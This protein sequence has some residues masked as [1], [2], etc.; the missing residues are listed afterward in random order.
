MSVVTKFILTAGLIA[1]SMLAGYVVRKRTDWPCDRMARWLMTFVGVFG[2]TSVS[3]LSIWKLHPVAA[4]AWLPSLGGL[5]V[6]LMTVLGLAAARLAGRPRGEVGLFSI[7]SGSGNNGFTMGGFIIFLLFGESGLGLVTMYSLMWTP[8]IVL[9][10]YP[11]ARHCASEKPTE[12]LGRLMLQNILDWRSIGLPITLV[13]LALA[14]AGVPRP[15]VIDRLNI[16][17][18]L[19]FTIT[20]MA[21]FG[22]GLRLH[23]ADVLAMRKTL[24]GL[25]VMRFVVALGVGL[26]LAAMTSLTPWPLTGMSRDV[27]IIEAFVPTAVTMVA[28]ANMFHLLPRQASVLFVVNTMMYLAV[29]LPVVFWVYRNN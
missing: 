12:S 8:M 23:V 2:Y 20:P 21:Y 27:F 18:V 9:L 3:F 16:V 26:A 28:V 13:G 15:E 6:L 4:D 17:D 19:V 1:V 14:M 22:I 29:V 25:A 7:A 24:A 11:I 10:A 5:H